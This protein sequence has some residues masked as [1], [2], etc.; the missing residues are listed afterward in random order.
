MCVSWCTHQ[1]IKMHLHGNMQ[2]DVIASGLHAEQ[3]STMF[4]QHVSKIK[5]KTSHTSLYLCIQWQ[6]LQLLFSY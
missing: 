3:V 2:I 6:K 5:M 4:F 1:E